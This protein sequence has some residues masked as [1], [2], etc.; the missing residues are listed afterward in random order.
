MIKLDFKGLVKE[1]LFIAKKYKVEA[2]L[3]GIVKLF[4]LGLL[5]WI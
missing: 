2:I 3:L 1:W 4:I 5:T